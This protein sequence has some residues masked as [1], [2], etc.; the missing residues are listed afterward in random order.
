MLLL[1]EVTWAGAWLLHS[2]AIPSAMPLL[3]QLL[4]PHP[5]QRL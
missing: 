2:K 5:I 4:R 3:K 1:V